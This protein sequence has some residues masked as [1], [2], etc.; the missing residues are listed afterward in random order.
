MPTFL[1]PKTETCTILWYIKR[2]E[3]DLFSQHVFLLIALFQFLSFSKPSNVPKKIFVDSIDLNNVVVGNSLIYIN[4]YYTCPNK[5]FSLIMT[6]KCYGWQIWFKKSK[7]WNLFVKALHV[8]KNFAFFFSFFAPTT[9]QS[10]IFQNLAWSCFK[11][12]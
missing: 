2:C 1:A 11:C 9:E 10:S 6:L 5:L 7:C 8:E 4:V 12:L 3:M